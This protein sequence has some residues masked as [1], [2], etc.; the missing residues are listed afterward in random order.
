M[1]ADPNA[2]D[3]GPRP[4]EAQLSNDQIIAKYGADLSDATLSELILAE[5]VYQRKLSISVDR[6]ARKERAADEAWMAAYIKR[7]GTDEG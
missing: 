6:K 5:L 1:T 2:P 4:E 7:Y 3:P